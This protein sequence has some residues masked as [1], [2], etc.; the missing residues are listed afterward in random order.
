[1]GSGKTTVDSFRLNTVPTVIEK[2][3]SGL[4]PGIVEDLPY[5]LQVIELTLL[6]IPVL[7]LNSDDVSQ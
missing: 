4:P 3:Y 6:F 2:D 5:A 7:I 1:V